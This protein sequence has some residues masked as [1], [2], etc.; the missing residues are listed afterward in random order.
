MTTFPP[1]PKQIVHKASSRVSI[2]HKYDEA[3][4]FW[5]VFD[6]YGSNG[7]YSFFEWRLAANAGE[8]VDPASL[9]RSALLQGEGSDWIGPYIVEAVNVPDAKPAFTGGNHAFDGGVGGSATARTISVD[10]V[11]DGKPVADGAC[12]PCSEAVIVAVN[13][14]QGFNTKK[15]NGTGDAV[16]R[17]TVEFTIACGTVKVRHRMEML[18][19]VC[20]H[21]YY[22][23]QTVN[24]LWSG[25][26]QYGTDT[27]CSEPL[28]SF[29]AN[30]SGPKS[31]HPDIDRFLIRSPDG[32]H[33]V[34]AWLDRSVGLGRLD[35]LADFLPVAF[36]MNYGKT[37]FNLINGTRPIFRIGDV[38]AW[39]GGYSFRSSR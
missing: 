5:L 22:G 18:T 27:S 30:D 28:P 37:Y 25:E 8:S 32:R 14:V 38:L 19:D 39:C 11:A 26:V 12:V 21:K 10:V 23:L 33:E 9:E 2:G 31:E 34:L 6:H 20:I 3:H 7:L 1:H 36:T 24:S 17:E 16:L 13:E 4:D 15:E 35:W 29:G